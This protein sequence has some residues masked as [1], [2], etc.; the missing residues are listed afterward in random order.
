MMS[1]MLA[2]NDFGD[3]R[4]TDTHG[5]LNCFGHDVGQTLANRR[6]LFLCI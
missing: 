2:S 1:F 4:Y 6:L 3:A 5:S